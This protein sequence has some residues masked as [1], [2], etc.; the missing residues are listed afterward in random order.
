MT[1]KKYAE[2]KEPL[3]MG[4]TQLQVA[5]KMFLDPR[6]ISTIERKALAKVRALLAERNITAKDILED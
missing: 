3:D 4:M 6:T 5:D 1:Y 2:R